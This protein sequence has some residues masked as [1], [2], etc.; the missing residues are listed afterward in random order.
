VAWEFEMF[1]RVR[2]LAAETQNFDEQFRP[3][4]IDLGP[5][6]RQ[7]TPIATQGRAE[8]I[9]EHGDKIT[10]SDIRLV[11]RFS[12]NLEL[13]CARCLEPVERA[14]ETSFDLLYRPL[15]AIKMPDESSIG[16]ADTEIGYYQ[17]EGLLLEDVLKEQV[18]LAVPLKE[19][20][21]AECKGFCAGCGRNLNAE[22]CACVEPTADPRWSALKDLRDK[23]QK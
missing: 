10:I 9:E 15:G 5:D 13:R 18:L 19:V 2:D 3:G 23:L 20:C 1:I 11:G 17:G 6:I 22:P 7:Q 12:T 21:R 8:L 14:V 16:P 4:V